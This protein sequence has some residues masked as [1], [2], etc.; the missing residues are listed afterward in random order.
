M[1]TII[2][3]FIIAKLVVNIANKP[4]K[5][6]CKAKTIAKTAYY[7]NY[8]IKRIQA[9][10]KLQQQKQREKERALK[11]AEKERQ[12]QEKLRQRKDTALFEYD[13]FQGRLELI[14]NMIESNEIEIES[15]LSEIEKSK[16]KEERI[17]RI[18]NTKAGKDMQRLANEIEIY[19]LFNNDSTSTKNHKRYE[20]L[21]KRKISLESQKHNIEKKLLKCYYIINNS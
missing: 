13:Y 9:E 18:E 8:D 6:H 12:Q 20:Q 15:T 19:D 10:N 5:Y 2:I 21:L 11:Q 4:R 16:E 3:I 7:D 1:I 14:N 17:K